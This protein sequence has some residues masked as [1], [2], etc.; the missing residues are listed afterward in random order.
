[1]AVSWFKRELYPILVEYSPPATKFHY[2]SIHAVGKLR[3][4]FPKENIMTLK[5]IIMLVVRDGDKL[6]PKYL[7]WSDEKEEFLSDVRSEAW[8]MDMCN[9]EEKFIMLWKN[10]DNEFPIV[11]PVLE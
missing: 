8:E 5:A 6:N 4:R 10:K 9:A 3:L 7:A 1:M 2:N 11:I